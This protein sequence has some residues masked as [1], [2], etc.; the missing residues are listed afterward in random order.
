MDDVTS[1]ACLN[2]GTKT[3]LQEVKSKKMI[4]FGNFKPKCDVGAKINIK[5]VALDMN[6]IYCKCRI[7]A[8]DVTSH[9]RIT[10][11]IFFIL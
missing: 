4:S 3:D 7:E 10:L 8:T 1:H 11:Q 9:E 2:Y 6:K 5:A